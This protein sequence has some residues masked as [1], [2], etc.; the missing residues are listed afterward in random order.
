MHRK[1]QSKK[2]IF[3]VRVCMPGQR[4]AISPVVQS[5][6]EALAQNRCACGKE[7][8]IET[9]LREALANAVV[10][11]CGDNASKTVECTLGRSARG[12]LI[13][14]VLDSGPGFDPASVPSPVTD[15]NVHSDHGRGLYLIKPLMDDV[16]F[17]RGGREIRMVLR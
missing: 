2:G 9:A 14:V 17:E 16:W 12:E 5:L 10:H 7:F 6:M 4:C 1:E 3:H 11:G 13:I 15:K 8:E